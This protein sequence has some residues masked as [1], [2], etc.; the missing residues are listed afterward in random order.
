MGKATL[1]NG[2]FV[3]YFIRKFVMT[4][5]LVMLVA[6]SAQSCGA[7]F[8]VEWQPIKKSNKT[9]H[10]K[11]N[12]F[13]DFHAAMSYITTLSQQNSQPLAIRILIGKGIHRLIQSVVIN[14]RVL[15]NP[16]STLIIEGVGV[17]CILSGAMAVSPILVADNV[18]MNNAL[19]A[20]SLPFMLKEGLQ[21]GGA[22]VS[23]QVGWPRLFSPQQVFRI[24]SSPNSGYGKIRDVSKANVNKLQFDGINELSQTSG[25][26]WL[27]GFFG[28][29]FAQELV[30][31][32]KQDADSFVSA[33]PLRYK[34][35][36]GGRV[37]L[38]N[39]MA[40]LDQEGEYVIDDK[41]GKIYFLLEKKSKVD[42][43]EVSMLESIFK[44]SNVKNISFKN[45]ILEKTRGDVIRAENVSDISISM[46]TMR[47]TDAAAVYISGEH[48]SII[49]NEVYDTGDGAILLKSGD[50]NTMTASGSMIVSNNVH[51][52]SRSLKTMRGGI[53]VFGVGTRIAENHVYDAPHKGII[54]FGNEHV[55]ENNIIDNVMI[56]G[57][58]MGA[59]YIGR[60]WAADGNVIR[61]N[62]VHNIKSVTPV[63]AVGIYLDD[64]VSGV[65]VYNNYIA[66]VDVGIM[67]GGGSS[68]NIIDNYIC[69]ASV[70][71]HIDSR[72]LDYKQ[73]MKKINPELMKNFI[74][75]R[76]A[77][78]PLFV[79]YPR[80]N[81]VVNR[82]VPTDNLFRDN[83]YIDSGPPRIV[84]GAA[85]YYSLDW[86]KI[87][88][89][90]EFSSCKELKDMSIK[91]PES[92]ITRLN[93]R[94]GAL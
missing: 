57:G 86:L 60:D 25:K 20:V 63:A 21:A 11:N 83:Y 1:N 15:S 52:Y 13:A 65:S 90:A 27:S 41:L 23:R 91:M 31:F 46:S 88:S 72:G 47:H 34:A 45:L 54:I 67:V 84:G 6:A 68:N 48:I 35:V 29:E 81:Q 82:S 53:Q 2:L 18:K 36:A 16:A 30:Q 49:D 66:D 70:A 7:A 19:F 55:V 62:I 89:K 44:L 10:L 69:T 42:I 8:T 9:N 50:R 37:R 92:V 94:G 33:K 87:P 77:K 78:S 22:G 80:L 14:E 12:S 93:E 28:K 74:S 26:V 71:L 61:A 51:D 64:Q 56:E 24:A 73:H 3:S 39:D 4:L 32:N 5:L 17:G 43:F 79:K 38:V 58:D 85:K 75:L 40:A 76:R 59:I